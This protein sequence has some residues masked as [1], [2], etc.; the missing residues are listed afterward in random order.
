[1]KMNKKLNRS[2]LTLLAVAVI[3]LL[4]VTLFIRSGYKRTYKQPDIILITAGSLRPD[5]LSAY[6]YTLGNTS[7]IDN[8]AKKGFVFMNAYTSTPVAAHS[9]ASILT[10]RPGL[11]VLETGGERI[12][13]KE[14]IPTLAGMLKDTGYVTAASV[15]SP[16]VSGN[17]GLTRGFDRVTSSHTSPGSGDKSPYSVAQATT[18][19]AVETFTEMASGDRPVFMWIQYSLPSFPYA[20]PPDNAYLG[21]RHP[22][23]I[24]VLMIDY[25]LR[26]LEEA[27]KKMKRWNE[28]LLILTS[29]SGA[30]LNEH[31]E[32][33]SGILL[34]NTT[35]R[36]PLIIRLPMAYEGGKI[37]G[38]VT[39]ADIFPTVAGFLG[40]EIPAG[41]GGSDLI[42]ATE[43]EEIPERDIFL[44]SDLGYRKF[45]WSP[46]FAVISGRYKYIEQASG[47]K[48]FDLRRDPNEL[49][50]IADKE[51]ER[52]EEM[53][54]L[55][56]KHVK[57]LYPELY[58]EMKKSPDPGKMISINN[59]LL[60]AKPRSLYSAIA[61][62]RSILKKDPD[63]RM[64]M[65]MLGRAYYRDGRLESAAN[66][67]RKML[68]EYPDSPR[69]LETLAL[70][71]DR[72][73]DNEAAV[74]YYKKVLAIAPG[75][76]VTLNN[77][78]WIYVSE[79]RELDEAARMA[80]KALE[81][82]PDN[83]TFMDTLASIY[84]K[85]G[86]E[87][88]AEKLRSGIAEIRSKDDQAD[89]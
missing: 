80:E 55:L 87:E 9:Y 52:S 20:V 82:V 26:E 27:L 42:P 35:V 37:E 4:A 68:E 88:K 69:C 16:Y 29:G 10:G 75:S 30:A 7:L 72:Q 17:T 38:N 76:P 63:N 65:L 5:H 57:E 8:I 19:S 47:K 31:D 14:D 84:E 15:S 33:A 85:Q 28:C 53:S 50:D 41:T 34:Y 44:G 71:S 54:S 86:K 67:L 60:S 78:A 12:R 77:L 45:G 25:Q 13:L 59:V 83:P 40:A 3:M 49:V 66:V 1:M 23:D 43:G 73:G 74:K 70:I 22:Y 56:A 36:V 21:S 62:Y 58:V 81:I 18:R 11:S 89:E 48:L 24:Q 46:V 2:I 32:L 51:K 6:G 61:M 79:N 39:L 64:A